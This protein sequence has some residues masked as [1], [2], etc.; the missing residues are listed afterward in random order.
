MNR[1]PYRRVTPPRHTADTYT[2]EYESENEPSNTI[3]HIETLI[4]Q[5]I[6][7]GII[8]VI[9]LIAGITDIAPAAA[10]RDGIRRV[11]SGAETLDELIADVRQFGSDW[12]DIGFQETVVTPEEFYVPITDFPD[13]AV[14]FNFE[15]TTFPYTYNEDIY[16]YLPPAADEQVSNLT[17]PE[18]RVTP[19][20]WD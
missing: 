1:T 18:P 11:L 13:E 12:L 19:G 2:R 5:C 9:V 14:Y 15:Q 16:E 7:S 20:L 10:L 6:I 8:M 4:M 3:S 17:V